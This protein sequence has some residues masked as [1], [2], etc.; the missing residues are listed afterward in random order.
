MKT[1]ANQ[2]YHNDLLYN[3]LNNKKNKMMNMYQK[4]YI[5]MIKYL[6]QQIFH[7]DLKNMLEK[8][9]FNFLSKSKNAIIWVTVTSSPATGHLR[10]A[11]RFLN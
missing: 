4:H 5:F 6:K 1:F 11:V 10:T 7:Q 2:I 3:L 9:Q 8:K